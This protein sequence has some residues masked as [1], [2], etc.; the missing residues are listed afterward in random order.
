MA[1]PRLAHLARRIAEAKKLVET[2]GD[3]VAFNAEGIRQALG[4]LIQADVRGAE[5]DAVV[6]DSLT[7]IWA[8]DR[9]EAQ[10]RADAWGEATAAQIGEKA[11]M[12]AIARIQ[13]VDGEPAWTSPAEFEP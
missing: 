11:F 3:P 13:E 5:R 8:V 12:T 4:E 7:R 6:L 1:T 2:R 9:A 10:R